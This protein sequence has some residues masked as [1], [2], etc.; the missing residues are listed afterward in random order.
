MNTLLRTG[1]FYPGVFSDAEENPLRRPTAFDLTRARV[2]GGAAA[3]RVA[4]GA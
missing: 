3:E 2:Q 4:M 1:R